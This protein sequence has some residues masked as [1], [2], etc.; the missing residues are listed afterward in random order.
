MTTKV[1]PKASCDPENSYEKA[2][3]E[4]GFWKIFRN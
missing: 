3:H 4:E 1:V 2:G